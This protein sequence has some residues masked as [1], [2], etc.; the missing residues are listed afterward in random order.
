M[1]SAVF[2][3]AMIAFGT[4]VVNWTT[5]VNDIWCGLGGSGF[6]AA[7]SKSGWDTYSDLTN[8]MTGTGYEA[9]GT[10]L[11][12]ITVALNSNVAQFDSQN[13]SWTSATFTAYYAY[14]DHGA[15][16]TTSGNPLISY[17]DLGG[18]Q[19][20][21]AGTLTLQWASSG[22]FNITITAAA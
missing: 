16:K 9:G 7:V 18:A 21:V 20:V 6:G 15:T 12:V 4:A 22:V 10:E 14:T 13:T 5:D 2:D 11:D 19:A 1:A 3:N 8:E 17:H